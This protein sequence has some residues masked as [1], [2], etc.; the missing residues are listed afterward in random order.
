MRGARIWLAAVL[1]VGLAAL[2]LYGLGT[3]AATVLPAVHPA[4]CDLYPETREPAR[5]ERDHPWN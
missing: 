5:C 2:Y 4:L 3:L 1:A